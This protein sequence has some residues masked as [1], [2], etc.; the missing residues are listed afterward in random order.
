MWEYWLFGSCIVLL[1]LML[2]RS[3]DPTFKG[4][5]KGE[6][7]GMATIALL[8]PIIL[9]LCIAVIMLMNVGLED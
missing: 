6:L 5:S 1:S 3:N 9:I 7:A 2:G 4:I 8:W